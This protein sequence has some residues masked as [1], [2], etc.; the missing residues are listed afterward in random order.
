VF[1][2]IALAARIERAEADLMTRAA[3]A[4]GAWCPA[5]GAFALPLAG[6]HATFAG[7]GSPFN[8]LAGL[9][10]EGVPADGDL[11]AVED[12]FAARDAPVQ[13]ELAHLAVPELGR[14]LTRRGYELVSFENVLGIALA[15]RPEPEAPPGIRVRPSGDEE[16]EA[17]L[18]VVTRAGLEPDANGVPS[19]ER[20]AYEAARRAEWALVA[21]GA[22]RYSADRDGVLVG[23]AG[24]RLARGIAQLTGA[25]TLPAHRRRGVQTALLAAR[26]AD[27][28][29]AGCDLAVITTQPASRSQQNAQRRGFE[30][31][32]T[33]AILVKPA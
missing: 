12:A 7:T 25:A 33:R 21:A 15:A 10:F 32:Y 11:A 14:V 2:D 8:K 19:H 23:G 26:L 6:G 3:R 1:C 22:R 30:L 16:L 9:G 13:V 18:D 28:A 24:L 31:L 27:A 5:S 4:I 17:W 20:F 29:A